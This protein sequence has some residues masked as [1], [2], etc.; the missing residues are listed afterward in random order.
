M[1]FALIHTIKD[2]AGWDEAI[3][4]AGN[5]LPTGFSNPYSLL[6]RTRARR[7]ASGMPCERSIYL[8]LAHFP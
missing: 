7:C 1:D 6:Q 4:G 3:A 8:V 2:A 5:N